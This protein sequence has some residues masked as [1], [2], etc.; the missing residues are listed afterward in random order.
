VPPGPR[1]YVDPSPARA[2]RAGG[3]RPPVREWAAEQ[4]ARL[5]PSL[6]RARREYTP[7]IVSRLKLHPA[8]G[9]ALAEHV[10]SVAA[11]A[12][13]DQAIDDWAS[14]LC[15]PPFLEQVLTR[16]A[17]GSFSAGHLERATDWNRVRHEE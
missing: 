12:T 3:P 1:D 17:P 16:E 2:R 10:R 14:V 4:C 5:Y 7:A 11:P 15:L 13:A 9:I 6:P 8:I